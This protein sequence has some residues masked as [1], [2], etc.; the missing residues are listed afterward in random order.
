MVL[1]NIKSG[2]AGCDRDITPR[3]GVCDRDITALSAH[4]LISHCLG[5]SRVTSQKTDSIITL[6][7]WSSW[8]LQVIGILVAPR[9]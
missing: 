2:K 1:K 7:L 4:A 8:A 6:D 3:L 5:N 9:Y